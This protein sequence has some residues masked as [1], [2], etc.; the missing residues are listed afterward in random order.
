MT[1]AYALT[2]YRSQVQMI[3]Y[4]LIDIATPLTGGLKS[5]LHS[6]EVPA[7]RQYVFCEISM[8]SYS[9]LPTA[10]NLSRLEDDGLEVLNTQTKKWWK[11]MGRSNEMARGNEMAYNAMGD[12]GHRKTRS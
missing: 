3:P 12:E 9:K 8:R 7:D 10:Q 4:V 1:T 2:D 5:M 6:H 11:W